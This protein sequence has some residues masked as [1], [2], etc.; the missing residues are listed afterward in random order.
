MRVPR[1]GFPRFSFWLIVLASTAV[2]CSSSSRPE[3][4]PVRGKVLV[5][6]KP[7]GGVLLT[8]LPAG[9]KDPTPFRPLAITSED[10]SFLVTTDEEDGAPAGEYV[11]TMVWKDA[12]PTK[13]KKDKNIQ[14]MM[15]SPQVDK[16]GG[17]YADRKKGLKVKIEKGPNE[18]KTFEL[19]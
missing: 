17:K 15:G 14:M 16:L 7:A 1:P 4:F 2:S 18:L 8:F 11:V 9:E 10:G 5:K 19:K 3:L 6:N 13:A 12:A